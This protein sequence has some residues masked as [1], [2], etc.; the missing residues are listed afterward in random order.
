MLLNQASIGITSRE[1][2]LCTFVDDSTQFH[3]WKQQKTGTR[4][5]ELAEKN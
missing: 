5:Y 3:I 1:K 4:C 2:Q